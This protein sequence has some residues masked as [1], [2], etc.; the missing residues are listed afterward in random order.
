MN[1]SIK[2]QI[3]PRQIIDAARVLSFAKENGFPG[4]DILYWD[5]NNPEC[6]YE[7]IEELMEDAGECPITLGISL[8]APAM[9]ASRTWDE[10]ADELGPVEYRQNADGDG[11]RDGCPNSPP[12]S[13]PFHPPSC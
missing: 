7:S 4:A 8:N 2:A 10:D 5:Q 12:T 1:H 9:I 11:R 6:G 13:S 3:V